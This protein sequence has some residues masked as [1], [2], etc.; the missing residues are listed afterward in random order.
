MY[1]VENLAALEARVREELSLLDYPARPWVPKRR[2][3]GAPVLD[4]LIVG[5][6]QGGLA[7]VFGL[8]R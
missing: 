5:A 3:A 7:T 6:G 4:V 2:H 8:I 1:P